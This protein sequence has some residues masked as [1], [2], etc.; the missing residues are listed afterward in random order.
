MR[1]KRSFG[2]CF[3]VLAVLAFLVPQVHAN[4]GDDT[5][6]AAVSVALDHSEVMSIS[7]AGDHNWRSFTLTESSAVRIET[8]SDG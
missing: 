7:S 8:I 2:I 5:C 3:I 6:D 1:K 4:P